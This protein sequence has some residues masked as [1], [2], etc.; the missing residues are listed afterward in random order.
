MSIRQEGFFLISEWICEDYSQ[1]T[2]E[3]ILRKSKSH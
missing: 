3:F 2:L 1:W